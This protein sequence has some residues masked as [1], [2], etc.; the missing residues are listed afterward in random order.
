VLGVTLFGYAVRTDRR[1]ARAGG[2]AALVVAAWL[3]VGSAGVEVPEAYTLPLAAVL[4]LYSGRRLATA[5]SWPSWGPALIVGY[6]PSVCLTL[7][8]PDLLRMLL[9]VAAATLTTTAA[10]GWAVRAPFLVGAA[11]LVTVGV[12]RLVAVLPAP[13]L[14][15]F[16]VAGAVLLGVGAGYESRRRQARE[17]IASL[18]DMR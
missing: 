13:G 2:C 5:P 11:T 9:V 17:A 16:V 1:P 12:G 10:T 8:D 14:I 6:G 4:L 7:V 3:A 18:A 15:A